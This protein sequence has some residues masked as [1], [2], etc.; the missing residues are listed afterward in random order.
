MSSVSFAGP[1]SVH[2]EVTQYTVG[3]L[4]A[5]DI[6]ATLY[7]IT[8]DRAPQMDGQIWWAVRWMGRCLDALGKWDY[9]PIPS[10]RTKAWLKRY[11][12]GSL[13]AALAAAVKAAP[14]V[15]INGRTARGG[16]QW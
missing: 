4:P 5:G 3:L 8:V 2:V 1:A 9:E 10:E 13:D 6:N 12:F 14:D 7:G 15:T 11:R 16:A